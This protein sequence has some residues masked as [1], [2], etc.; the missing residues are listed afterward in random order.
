MVT[1]AR[2]QVFSELDSRRLPGDAKRAGEAAGKAT[3]EGYDKTW[4]KGFDDTLTKAGREALRRWRT[5]G[6]LDGKEYGTG[7]TREAGI[8]LNAFI[9]TAQKNFN[10]LRLDPD[11]LG[12][13]TKKFDDAGVATGELQRQ[14]VT[15]RNEGLITKREFEGAAKQID[16][17]AI[18]QRTSAEES[19]RH[20]NAIAKLNDDLR[21]QAVTLRELD[22]SLADKVATFRSYGDALRDGSRANRE[23]EASLVNLNRAQVESAKSAKEM[24]LHWKSLP[25]GMRQVIVWTTAIVGGMEQ[26]SVL[27]SAAGAGILSLGGSAIALGAGVGGLAA[28]FV[29]LNKEIEELPSHLRPLAKE[30]QS[31]TGVFGEMR[32]EIA[33]GAFPQMEG[34]FDRLGRTLRGLNP[35][36]HQLG[37]T[38][39]ELFSDM[40]RNIRPGTDGFKELS[41]AI[42]LASPNLD[43]LARSTG[44]FGLSLIRSFNKAQPLVE[45]FTGYIGRLTDQFDEFTRSDEFGGWVR[46][47]STVWKEF[48]GLLDAAGRSL[49]DLVTPESIGRS[50]EFQRNLTEFMPSLTRLLQVAGEAD[51]FGIIALGLNDLGIALEPLAEPAE[52]LAEALNRLI[53]I[54]IEQFALQLQVLSTITAPV[55]Q[56]LAD[57]LNAI[58][59][60]VLRGAANGLL[61]LGGAVAAFRTAKGIDAA[62]TSFGLLTT[63]LEKIPAVG[64]RAAS[65]LTSLGRVAG[66]IAAAGTAA[67]VGIPILMDWVRAVEQVDDKT[68]KLVASSKG[69]P[70]MWDTW[71]EGVP[72]NEIKDWNGALT[73][74]TNSQTN[75]FRNLT[76]MFS[77]NGQA[78]LE[79]V[80]MF[81]EIDKVL[82]PMAAESLPRAAAEFSA[83]ATSVGATDEQM[84]GMINEMNV[85]KQALIDQA[86]SMGIAVTDQNLLKLATEGLIPVTAQAAA[87]AR[88]QELALGAM[89]GRSIT[90]GLAIDGLA[91]KIRNFGNA[92]LTTR[93]AERQFQEAVDGVTA[94]V[95]ANGTTLEINEAQGRA[96]LAALDDIAKSALNFAAATYEQ[97]NSVDDA[98]AAV[99]SGRAELIRQL[100]QFNITGQA[101]EDYA[102]ELGLIPENIPT[103]LELN[104]LGE[105]TAQI[106]AFIYKNS[107]KKVTIG[108]GLGGSGGL[109][110]ASGGI[111]NQPTHVYAGEAGREAFV[112]LERPLS[113]VD[114]SVRWLSAIA[115][116]KSAPQSMASG[117]MVGGGGR[118]ITVAPGAIVIY[119]RS[120][121]SRKVAND[122]LTRLTEEVMG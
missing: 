26:I 64:G 39:G 10:S 29:T 44:T 30:F 32:E 60:D 86:E 81:D 49:N 45:D 67:A 20:R 122:V 19:Q 88:E 107:R 9:T 13:F 118:Q 111:L 34:S 50:L 52:D 18:S 24:D 35:E 65:A 117:G 74:L 116:G 77:E 48:G 119:D 23:F 100:A 46:R 25:H 97:T 105:A 112:P 114:P 113:Q 84:L 75:G 54:G 101:A 104:G 68:R 27:G 5:Q 15:L 36:M 59:E 43:S 11:F 37:V 82:G 92:T 69:L 96:N 94:S 99:A 3:A 12:D 4:T 85:F 103:Y 6:K 72:T 14:I 42:A 41:R 21:T 31:F 120:G 16:A 71:R 121:D 80:G 87:A 61:I 28:V 76:L 109:A 57:L 17:F 63:K 90:S 110:M 38:T 108:M 51:V 62:V 70:E 22:A 7:L 95:A 83:Y 40:T 79:L 2:V 66:P 55:A 102:D 115:Q 89:E 8:R 73:E 78:A 106:D 58:P 91:E 1:V 33:S 47:S 53:T 56:S 93:D 98:T